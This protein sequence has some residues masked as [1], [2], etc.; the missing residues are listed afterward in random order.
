MEAI[1]VPHTEVDLILVNGE[2]VPFEHVLPDGAHV[3]VYPVFEGFDICSLTRLRPKP[4]RTPRF[5]LDVH[6]GK[7]ARNMRMLGLDLLYEN[8]LDDTAII[9]CAVRDK[10][11]ILTRDLGI[12]K[13]KSVTHGY[14]VRSTNSDEQIIEVINRFDLKNMLKPFT[15]CIVCNGMLEPVDKQQ[16]VDQ[17]PPD[18]AR[19][20]KTF[21]KCNKCGKIY[22]RGGHFSDMKRRINLM[23]I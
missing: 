21:K 1:G 14:W 4:L 9:E 16:V 8:K 19:Y 20:F 17:V 23:N 6:L 3:S 7:L 2:S 12:L 10:R 5:V 15:R 18:T 13:N 22:W 11:I